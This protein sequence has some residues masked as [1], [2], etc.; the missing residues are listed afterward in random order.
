MKALNSKEENLWTFGVAAKGSQGSRSK[1]LG[2]FFLGK[3]DWG[4]REVEIVHCSRHKNRATHYLTKY[5]Y[6]EVSSVVCI[7]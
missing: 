2:R 7:R 5:A 4:G 3:R 6:D 1:R